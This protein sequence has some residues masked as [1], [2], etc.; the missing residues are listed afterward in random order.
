M[1]HAVRKPLKTI[2]DEFFATVGIALPLERITPGTSTQE[3]GQSPVE[4]Y[5]GV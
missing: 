2:A 3:Q 4:N 5:S 1:P